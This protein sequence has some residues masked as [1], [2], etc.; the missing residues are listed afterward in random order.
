MVE[1]ATLVIALRTIL[2]LVRIPACLAWLA[3]VSMLAH[4]GQPTSSL[5]RIPVIVD[6]ESISLQMRIYKPDGEGRFPTLV[7][8]H[9]STGYSADPERFKQSVDASAVAGF[10]VERGWAV[11]MPARRGR[12]GS[13]GQYDEGLSGN[14]TGY[15]CV[16]AISLAG[17][18]RALRD[19]DAAVKAIVALPFVDA[20]RVVVGGVSRGG[21]LSIAYAGMNP[22]QVRG[23]VNF[24]GG[25]LGT[26]C[27]TMSSVNQSLFLRGAVYPSESIWLYADK[28]NYYP[29][30][31]RHENF[32]VF[33]IAGGKGS[34]LEYRVS[35]YIGHEMAAFPYVWAT[36]L[37]AYL[38]RIHLPWRARGG[39]TLPS[40]GCQTVNHFSVDVV[41]D[42]RLIY[43]YI[44]VIIDL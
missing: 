23:V 9:G 40:K 3:S 10:F 35:E 7:F 11:I 8:N 12:A 44:V 17:A 32:T 2:R 41:P 13:D 14:R 16:P 26:R 28:D 43:N 1:R 27:P 36:D 34:F 5:E 18:D 21:I 37:E 30:S 19:V 29:L 15:S 39:L 20:S 38:R 42:G 6:G 31:H 4:G 22:A 25:W 24:V 33:T